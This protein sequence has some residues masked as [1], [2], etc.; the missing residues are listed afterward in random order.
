MGLNYPKGSDY[1]TKT[2]IAKDT[3][4]YMRQRIRGVVIMGVV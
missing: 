3:A 1:D 2:R 4:D